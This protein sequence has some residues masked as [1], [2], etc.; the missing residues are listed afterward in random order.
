MTGDPDDTWLN[1]DTCASGEICATSSEMNAAV[2]MDA[3]GTDNKRV[4]CIFLQCFVLKDDDTIK[5][6]GFNDN[7]ELA[8][9]DQVSSQLDEGNPIKTSLFEIASAGPTVCQ[10]DFFGDSGACSQ[11]PASSTRVAGDLGTCTTCSCQCEA[12]HYATG[13]TCLACPA[14]TAPKAAGDNHTDTTSHCTCNANFYGNAGSCTACPGVETHVA[15]DPNTCTSCGCSCAAGWHVEKV[16]SEPGPE[17]TSV[18]GITGENKFC[19]LYT[20]PSPRDQA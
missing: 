9:G 7:G 14:N 2:K 6:I 17:Y 1:P 18:S 4:D 15:G 20:S 12:N 13:T 10:Q 19:L 16:D 3:W 5:A 8:T 11:C